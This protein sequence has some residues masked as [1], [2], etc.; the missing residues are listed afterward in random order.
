VNFAQEAVRFYV[1]V[2]Q[3]ARLRFQPAFRFEGSFL[4]NSSFLKFA[5]PAQRRPLASSMGY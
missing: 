2:M 4:A 1:A 3:A 5:L